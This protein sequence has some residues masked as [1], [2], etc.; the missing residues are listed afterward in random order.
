MIFNRNGDSY[1]SLTNTHLNKNNLQKI[2]IKDYHNNDTNLSPLDNDMIVDNFDDA[3]NPTGCDD[4]VPFNSA[5]VPETFDLFMN[6]LKDKISNNKEEEFKLPSS[7]VPSSYSSLSSS[8]TKYANNHLFS[9]SNLRLSLNMRMLTSSVDK[10]LNNE[11]LYQQPPTITTNKLTTSNRL[12]SVNATENLMKRKQ[13]IADAKNSEFKTSSPFKSKNLNTTVDIKTGEET[14]GIGEME[15]D[16]VCGDSMR[17]DIT[18]S[19]QQRV[20]FNKTYTSWSTN[21]HQLHIDAL[22][23]KSSFRRQ[24]NVVHNVQEFNK[25]KDIAIND[26]DNNIDNVMEGVEEMEIDDEKKP[27]LNRTREIFTSKN[28]ASIK[29]STSSTASSSGASSI[30][31][32]TSSLA[33]NRALNTTRDIE[34]SGSESSKKKSSPSIVK[35]DKIRFSN[36]QPVTSIAKPSL[37]VNVNSK[38]GVKQPIVSNKVTSKLTPPSKLASARI[39][40]AV[41][42]AVSNEHGASLSK[43]KFPSPTTSTL[44]KSSTQVIL[45]TKTRQ[46]LT[47]TSSNNVLSP[48]LSSNS[49][50]FKVPSFGFQKPATNLPAPSAS[51]SSFL[52]NKKPLTHTL[53]SNE[54]NNFDEGTGVNLNRLSTASMTS[55]ISSTSSSSSSTKENNLS[56]IKSSLNA[57]PRMSNISVNS[58][59]NNNINRN[60]ISAGIQNAPSSMPAPLQSTTNSIAQPSTAVAATKVAASNLPVPLK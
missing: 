60:K 35:N 43:L 42:Q 20:V 58:N 24:T 6:N 9:N 26:N 17:L 23:Q 16:S 52:N 38:M 3:I 27:D 30:A 37:S 57:N 59:I 34:D 50:V 8:S 19:D 1:F 54:I 53:K 44:T 13:I 33:T 22:N 5:H 15:I 36:N 14:K 39:A 12:S 47:S 32:S 21:E 55:S 48:T 7:K 11:D 49:S 4:A 51:T 2:P 41:S 29:S 56:K 46:P 25:T 40:S 31:S 10:D 28:V 45:Q 18:D